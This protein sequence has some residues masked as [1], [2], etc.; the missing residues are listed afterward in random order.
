MT[1]DYQAQQFLEKIKYR[2]KVY[3]LSPEESRKRLKDTIPLSGI[4]QHVEVVEEHQVSVQNGE[5]KVRVYRPEGEGPFPI[6]VY[7]HGG[8]WVIGDLE[9]A[10]APCREITNEAQCIVVSVDYR[11]APEHK[12]PTAVEDGYA[13]V[14]WV[15]QMAKQLKGDATRIAIGGDSAGGN[16]AAVIAI[17]AR[18][19]K[20]PP[21][22]W[23]ILIYP[24]TSLRFDTQSYRDNAEGYFLT[25]QSMEYFSALYLRDEQDKESIYAS[26]LLAE[27]VS[28][29]PP[30]LIITAEYD[31]LRD[32]GKLYADRLKESGVPV[33]YTCYYG[34]IHGFFGLS[35]VMEQGKTA[36]K[37]VAGYLKSAFKQ[38]DQDR[39]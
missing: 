17:L 15:W 25:R 39:V 30:T 8:G 4:P 12:F 28:A 33:E 24:V 1:L 10:D 2:P 6:F 32:E 29:L 11:L 34:M 22:G 7:F 21:I 3:E 20:G 38:E 18:E 14:M 13:A 16:L 31:P 9:T 36:I 5:I 19:R 35:G 37:Q 26:P 27:D 23:Q